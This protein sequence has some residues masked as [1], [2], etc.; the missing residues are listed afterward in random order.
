PAGRCRA[1][2]CRLPDVPPSGHRPARA[3]HGRL[4]PGDHGEQP[5]VPDLDGPDRE[6]RAATQRRPA[7]AGTAAL[8]LILPGSPGRRSGPPWSG[9][10]RKPLGL[11][12]AAPGPA[13]GDRDRGPAAKALR[14]WT[15]RVLVAGVLPPEKSL[16]TA[17][18]D[19]PIKSAEGRGR[20]NRHGTGRGT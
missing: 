4:R 10:L 5:P 14:G 11:D 7:E 6:R 3:E 18:P 16:Q 19:R 12:R 9:L 13:A 17:A 1:R 2:D 15:S 8:P 20:P